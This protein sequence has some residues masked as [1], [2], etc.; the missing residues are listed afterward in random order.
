MHAG[1]V[2]QVPSGVQKDR[3]TPGPGSPVAATC[4][5]HVVYEHAQSV[6]KV[7]TDP[8]KH[9]A[10]RRHAAQFSPSQTAAALRFT[11]PIAKTMTEKQKKRPFYGSL[12]CNY[13][14]HLLICKAICL[15]A[16][17]GIEPPT[18]G[19]SIHTF[20][21]FPLLIGADRINTNQRLMTD[22]LGK[23]TA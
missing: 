22:T 5:E 19:F 11:K 2:S 4:D 23:N 1:E 3:R 16:W 21:Y 12:F 20:L 18:Q 6:A 8:A 14:A 15:V 9:Y 17:D 7:T 13:F 10:V